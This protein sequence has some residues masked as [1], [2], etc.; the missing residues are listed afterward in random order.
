MSYEAIG[1]IALKVAS[2]VAVGVWSSRMKQKEENERMEKLTDRMALEKY[3]M[4]QKKKALKAE[5][6]ILH[7]QI[8]KLESLKKIVNDK[9]DRVRR[10]NQDHLDTDRWSCTLDLICD[11]V[12][13]EK[14]IK[15]VKE[16]I[17]IIEAA[18]EKLNNKMKGIK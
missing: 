14:G 6:E 12:A 3:V 10:K 8:G 17:A 18:S 9:R 13:I 11:E 15:K 2:V 4:S 7:I 16:R 5:I 1:K